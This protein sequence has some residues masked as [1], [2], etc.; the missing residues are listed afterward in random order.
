MEPKVLNIK[1][2]K[3]SWP[4][5]TVRVDRR[6]PWGNPFAMKNASDAERNRVC[7]AFEEMAAKWL[8]ETIAALKKDLKGKNLACWCSP[9]KCHADTLLRIANEEW[10]AANWGDNIAERWAEMCRREERIIQLKEC[11]SKIANRI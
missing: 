10:S 4:E 1:S 11:R 5:N 7:D 2:I 9:K 3:G 6:S 8:P